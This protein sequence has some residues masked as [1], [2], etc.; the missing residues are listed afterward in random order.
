M[1]TLKKYHRYVNKNKNSPW[2]AE[3]IPMEDIKVSQKMYNDY[4]DTTKKVAK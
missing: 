3:I 1:P 2:I 4:E